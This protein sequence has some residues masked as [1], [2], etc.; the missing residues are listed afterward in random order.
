MWQHTLVIWR[1]KKTQADLG[2]H[3]KPVRNP[4]EEIQMGRILKNGTRNWSLLSSLFHT[5]MHTHIHTQVG[6]KSRHTPHKRNWAWWHIPTV[7]DLKRWKKEDKEPKAS[8]AYIVR[9]CFKRQNKARQ[10]QK[11]NSHQHITYMENNAEILRK[12][13]AKR[14]WWYMKRGSRSWPQRF[15]PRNVKKCTST[16]YD[17]RQKKFFNHPYETDK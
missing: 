6:R 3:S 1:L 2:L 17:D 15:H 4:S 12:T 11:I 14:I 8:L 5:C 10:E 13:F 16:P 7:P 9:P